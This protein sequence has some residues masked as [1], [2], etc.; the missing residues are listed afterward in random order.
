MRMFHRCLRLNKYVPAVSSAPSNILC[1]SLF[2]VT[3][4]IFL[5][6][7]VH[8]LS[9]TFKSKKH[10]S[11]AATFYLTSQLELRTSSENL[12]FLKNMFYL[13]K[14][15][16]ALAFSSNTGQSWKMETKHKLILCFTHLVLM[17]LILSPTYLKVLALRSVMKVLVLSKRRVYNYNDEITPIQTAQENWDFFGRLPRPSYSM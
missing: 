6:C 14:Y 17:M 8:T 2:F 12:Y 5:I 9:Q 11:T 15:Q 1:G 13:Q 16:H 3:S 7:L 10:L 4:C